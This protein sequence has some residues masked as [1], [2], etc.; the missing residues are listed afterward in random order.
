MTRPAS[1]SRLRDISKQRTIRRPL[2]VPLPIEG[3]EDQGDLPP[4]KV[5]WPVPS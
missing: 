4:T 2:L 1:L 5:E 3:V